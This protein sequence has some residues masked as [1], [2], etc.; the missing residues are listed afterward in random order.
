MFEIK[1]KIKETLC[2]GGSYL[3]DNVQATGISFG[4][5]RIQLLTKSI[6]EIEKY[7]IVSLNE[8]KKAIELA[9][10]L[11]KQGKNTTL[12]NEL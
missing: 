8:D 10:K 6:I 4:L 9:Q 1:S 3:L 12:L 2:A 5:E 7:L 11:R